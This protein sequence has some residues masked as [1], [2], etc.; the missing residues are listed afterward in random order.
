MSHYQ[1]EGVIKYE[2][3]QS[4]GRIC[5][6]G[7][8]SFRSISRCDLCWHHRCAEDGSCNQ[9]RGNGRG[10]SYGRMVESSSQEESDSG[11]ASR[12]GVTVTYGIDF[13]NV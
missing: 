4:K 10:S 12:R 11:S 5:D 13:H 7:P 9:G 6:C 1:Y 3:D 2:G 8:L